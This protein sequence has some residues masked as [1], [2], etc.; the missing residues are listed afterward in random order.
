MV[1]STG[2][3]AL[4]FALLPSAQG[5]R[6]PTGIMIRFLDYCANNLII[7]RKVGGGYRFVHDYMRQYLASAAFV[8]DAVAAAPEED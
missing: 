4:Y 6:S 3:T 2:D 1:E 8:A 7:L 5:A